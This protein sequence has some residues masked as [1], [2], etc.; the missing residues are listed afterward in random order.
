MR[1]ADWINRLNRLTAVERREQ[2]R[3]QEG[4][5]NRECSAHLFVEGGKPNRP[6]CGARCRDGRPCQA[7]AV[8]DAKRQ[9]LH[10]LRCRMHGGLSTGPKTAAGRA[11][12]LEGARK[13]AA[14]R[15]AR[16]RAAR[17]LDAIRAQLLAVFRRISPVQRAGARTSDMGL[18]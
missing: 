7:P 12:S 10:S 1:I 9:R 18:P 15:W 6:K 2:E 16:W 8:W 5:Q 11:R 17:E 14:V 4:Q 13:G 3:E